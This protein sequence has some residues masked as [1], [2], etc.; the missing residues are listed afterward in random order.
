MAMKEAR[1]AMKE[2]Q[3]EMAKEMKRA[4]KEWKE[5]E[6]EWAKGQKEWEKAQKEWQREQEKF[7]REQ[8]VFQREQLKWQA[9]IQAAKERLSTELMRDGLI[10]DTNNFSLKIDAKELKVN[11]KKQSEA[12][13]SKYQEIIES[14]DP[15]ATK[16][17]NW[18]CHYN[19]NG[20]E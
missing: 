18:N 11:N 14:M 8:S 13:R 4:A 15:G 2:Q 19:F 10:K 16:D 17:K 7:V 20:E 5:Q 3:K 1:E 9:K 12:L 6:K